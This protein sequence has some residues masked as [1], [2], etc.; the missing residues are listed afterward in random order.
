[1]ARPR[2]ADDFATIRGRMDELRRERGEPEEPKFGD[3]PQGSTPPNYCGTC[4]GRLP[5][6]MDT[7]SKVKAQRELESLAATEGFPSAYKIVTGREPRR[8]VTPRPSWAYRE[9]VAG[10]IEYAKFIRE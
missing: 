2:A 9:G 5:N 7:C 8:W 10:F 3:R 4:G 6:H 1:M